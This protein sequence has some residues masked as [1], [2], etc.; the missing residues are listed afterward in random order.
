MITE[1][2]LKDYSI[3]SY[4]IDTNQTKYVFTLDKL[5]SL[6]INIPEL[7]REINN[8]IVDEI[9]KYQIDHFNNTKSYKFM[10]ELSLILQDKK[11]FIIDGQHRYNAILKIYTKMPLYKI[12]VNVII[13]NSYFTIQD[14][15]I[16][17]NKSKPVP[18]HIIKTTMEVSQRELISGFRQKFTEKYKKYISNAKNPRKPNINIDNILDEFIDSFLMKQFHSGEDIFE[19]MEYINITKWK[20]FEKNNNSKCIDKSYNGIILYMCNDNDNEWITNQHWIYEFKTHKNNLNSLIC[21]KNDN[22]CLHEKDKNV[23]FKRQKISKSDRKKVW[24]REYGKD[25]EKGVCQVC[26]KNELNTETFECGHIVSH[27]NGGT[28]HITNLRPICG[29]CNKRMGSKNWNEF[30]S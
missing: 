15:F 14:A 7:Q 8:E 21:I 10:G 4:N 24:E 27:S 25:N 19:Y 6:D 29:P 12:C 2:I 5:V 28:S 30:T 17:L 16:L 1:K 18:E 26:K 11:L 22:L 3:V 9:V 23:S 13:P 20:Y